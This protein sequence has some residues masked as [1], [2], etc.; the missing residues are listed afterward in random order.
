MRRAVCVA[1]ALRRRGPQRLGEMSGV[2]RLSNATT[3][4][5]SCDR[6]RMAIVA[7]MR[8]GGRTLVLALALGPLACGARSQNECGGCVSQGASESTGGGYQPATITAAG[9]VS[10]SGTE[11]SPSAVSRFVLDVEEVGTSRRL[12]RI[13]F[14]GAGVTSPEV[15]KYSLSSLG[16]RSYVANGDAGLDVDT[17]ADVD[18]SADVGADAGEMIASDLEG[19]LEV[20]APRADYGIDYEYFVRTNPSSVVAIDLDVQSHTAF[21]YPVT[22]VCVD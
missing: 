20:V 15:G 11:G 18:A 22:T 16:A 13:E 2:R 4:H 21:Q 10:V 19:T 9:T 14:V 1:S 3:W 12:A 17:D 7:G 5:D 6:A 8:I